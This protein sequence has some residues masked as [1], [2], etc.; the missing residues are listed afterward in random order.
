MSAEP[1]DDEIH[2]LLAAS[3]ADRY[4][5]LLQT[6]TR[7]RT[8]WSLGD[9]EGFLL[10]QDD[11]GVPHVPV[12][13]GRRLAEICIPD[14][15]F[16]LKA[17]PIDLLGWIERWTPVLL[18]EERMVAAF[19]TPSGSGVSMSPLRLREDLE[20]ALMKNMDVKAA[21]DES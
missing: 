17:M 18:E 12:W 6:A 8:L 3:T 9:G 16:P 11:E 1:D 14:D 2:R 20:E 10:I 4:E 19:P 13:P 5:Y 21:G 7:E 15:G